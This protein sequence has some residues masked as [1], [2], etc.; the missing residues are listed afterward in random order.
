MARRLQS[1][2]RNKTEEALAVSASS[3]SIE[4]MMNQIQSQSNW[5]YS[6]EFLYRFSVQ[7]G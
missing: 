2:K 1:A 6:T 5:D 3:D 4:D 7:K